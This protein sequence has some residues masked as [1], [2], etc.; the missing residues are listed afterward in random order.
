M[1]RTSEGLAGGDQELQGLDRA[2]AIDREGHV[3]VDDRA[4]GGAAGPH[5]EAE[6]DVFQQLPLDGLAWQEARR[7]LDEPGAAG[8]EEHRGAEGGEVEVFAAAVEALLE[9]EQEAPVAGLVAQ[10]V[11][12]QAVFAPDHRGGP[13]DAGREHPPEVHVFGALDL[14][15]VAHG[16]EAV[17]D[18]LVADPGIGQGA[19]GGGIGRREAGDRGEAVAIVGEDEP[20]ALGAAVE[21]AWRQAAIDLQE[22]APLPEAVDD[23]AA[24]VERIDAQVVQRRDARR[25][26]GIEGVEGALDVE[27]AGVAV[28]V[29]GESEID[30]A[31]GA[32][33]AGVAVAHQLRGAVDVREPGHLDVFA[34]AEEVLVFDVERGAVG[35]AGAVEVETDLQRP[36]VARHPLEI[37]LAGILGDRPDGRFIQVA[38]AAQQPLGLAQRLRREGVAGMEQQLVLDHLG[39]GGAV[40][41]VDQ[42]EDAAALARPAGVED[43]LGD[44]VDGADL[45]A[46]G[47]RLP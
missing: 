20:E 6:A 18:E 7:G 9:A 30:Q 31:V 42:V 15:E 13:A 37:D 44:D 45:L 2:V 10:R 36:D 25:P 28:A 34:G 1:A 14:V 27:L 12:A 3:E 35:A 29:V 40:Q 17:L 5:P 21:Q 23:A 33:Q 38:V 19:V 24:V 8:I 43:V 22:V 26:A 47:G 4:A 39:S 16:D 32:A 11:A 41:A 46:R